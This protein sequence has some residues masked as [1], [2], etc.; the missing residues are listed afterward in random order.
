MAASTLDAWADC[1]ACPDCEHDLHVGHASVT[2]A[3]C[4]YSTA[5]ATPLDLRPRAPH[6]RA[7]AAR[8]IAVGPAIVERC[9]LGPPAR[10]YAGPRPKRDSSTLFSAVLDY[11]HPGARMLDLGC[12]PRDQ[13]VPAEHLGLRYLGVD[14]GSPAADLLAD[15][16][17]LPFRPETFD[18]VISYAVLEHLANPFLAAAAAARALRPG[19][20]FF[21][22]VSQGEPFHASYFHHTAWGL[23]EVL[24]SAGFDL[25]RL[26]PSYDTLRALATM[27]RY[28]RVWRWVLFAVAA[29]IA[30][31]PFLAPRRYLRWS[32]RE[33]A[34]DDIHRAAG[35]CFVAV[36]RS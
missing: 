21:G 36:K 29:A 17:A 8:V 13:A 3:R 34:L 18:L 19:G 20:V 28:P 32:P 35:L 6:A 12:G 4:G 16:H 1:L 11:C 2:C 24:D 22:T 5:V 33:R 30:R 15:A 10:A 9:T 31:T 14:I 7:L 26:W 23:A 25:Q 27:G